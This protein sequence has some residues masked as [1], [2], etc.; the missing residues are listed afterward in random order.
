MIL[1]MV[2]YGRKT[3]FLILRA[4]YRL[5][6]FENRVQSRTVGPRGEELHNLNSSPRIIRIMK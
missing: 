1:P 2:L 5:K 6:V 3:W 4:Q